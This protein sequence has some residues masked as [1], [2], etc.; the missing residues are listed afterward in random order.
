M[1][2]T[3]ATQVPVVA[4]DGPSGSGKGTL[5]ARLARALGF[6]LLDS[7]AIYRVAGL[8]AQ[9][10]G[11]ALD[12]A[13]GLAALCAGL[14]LEFEM[15]RGLDPPVRVLLAGEDVSEQIR[16]EA[17]GRLASTIAALP[18]VRRA[19]LQRQRD[20]A[21][22]PGLVADGRDMGTVVFSDATVKLFITASPLRRAQRRYKQLIAKGSDVTLSR[23]VEEIEAR[24]RRDTERSV[25]PLRPA[26][27]AVLIDTSELDA[28]A[29]YERAM[30]I[31]SERLGLKP[32]R[33]AGGNRRGGVSG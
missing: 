28:D 20:F 12:D 31:V 24:D 7:G 1:N 6:A 23:L 26:E 2:Q 17:C 16:S 33:A 18:A 11:V 19:L 29:V 9:R 8:A 21:R 10:A 25:A 5:S 27:D 32:L 14:Q 15:V 4:V 3:G 13:P 22:E 30:A